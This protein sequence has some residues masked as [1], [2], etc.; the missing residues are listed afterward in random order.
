MDVTDVRQ[1]RKKVNAAKLLSWWAQLY[2][3]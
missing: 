3:R 2:Q 1:A